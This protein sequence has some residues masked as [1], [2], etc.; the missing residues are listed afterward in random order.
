MSRPNAPG[1][2]VV[3]EGI[4]G[5]G[6]STVVRRLADYCRERGLPC[7]T[8]GEPTR[9][10]W[11][12][13]LRQSMVEGRLSLEEELA[14]FLRDR[15]EH[16]EKLIR[17]SMAEGKIVILDRYYLS[18]AAYQGARGADPAEILERNEQFAPKPDL[19]LLL[20]FDPEGGLQR[21]RARGDAPNTFE[22]VDQLV[23]VRG[24]FLG[25]DRPFVRRVDAGRAAEAVWE[26]CKGH[27]DRLL[28]KLGDAA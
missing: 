8:S 7:V 24:I 16:V 27:L 23:A 17:P 26:D 21:V 12:I 2:L 22:Q 25:I 20:D 11:G 18:T 19:V 10:P 15:S 13:K 28:V 14:L 3:V 5:A 4:D 6:K 9:G 1:W